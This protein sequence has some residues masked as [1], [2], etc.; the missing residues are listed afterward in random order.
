MSHPGMGVVWTSRTTMGE[1][2]AMHSF[3]ALD[4]EHCNSS[5][6][7]VCSVGV[8]RVV[9]SQV[10]A[11]RHWL[12]RPRPPF[13]VAGNRHLELTGLTMAEIASG[14]DFAELAEVVE[15]RIADAV[16]VVHNRS[17]DLPMWCQSSLASGRSNLPDWKVLDTV[18]LA[19]SLGLPRRLAELHQHFYGRPLPG[20]HNAA[21]DAAATARMAVLMLDIAGLGVDEVAEPYRF[22]TMSLA[23]VK[24]PKGYVRRLPPR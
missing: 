14:R 19:A 10:V 7:S 22:R 9:D 3:V 21:A 24:T 15:S 20:H 4:L 11:T 17:A 12:V 2:G 1:H 18:D 8:A 6:A 13:D 5:Y 16:V 23:D